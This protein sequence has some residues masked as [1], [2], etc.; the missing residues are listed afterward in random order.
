MTN[1]D[2]PSTWKVL[3]VDD[4][5]DNL[6][7]ASQLLTF[8]GAEVQGAQSGEEGLQALETMQPTFI[9]L[10]LSMPGMDGWEVLKTIRADPKTAATTV[11][12]LTGYT[13]EE[14]ERIKSAGFNGYITK[15]YLM[16]TFLQRIKNTLAGN[17]FQEGT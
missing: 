15:P 11:I 5:A 2:D 14:I 1:G 3:I 7:I 16:A 8:F 17:A 6:G 9:L 13:G 4:N 12:A 10:D